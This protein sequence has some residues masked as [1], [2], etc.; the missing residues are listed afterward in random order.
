MPILTS[1]G[2]EV[3]TKARLFFMKNGTDNFVNF[4]RKKMTSKVVTLVESHS[5]SDPRDRLVN[6]SKVCIKPKTTKEVSII[7]KEANRRGVLLVP[8]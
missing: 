1:I 4:L 3:L 2:A 8:V 7:L 5:V 6:K